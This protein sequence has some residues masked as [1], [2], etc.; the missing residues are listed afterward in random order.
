[1]AEEN[2]TASVPPPCRTM[3]HD[4]TMAD[5][6][7]SNLM[8]EDCHDADVP[9]YD[10]LANVTH[11][12]S[13]VCV[14]PC[15][16]LLLYL[17][18]PASSLVPGHAVR[19][20]IILYIHIYIYIYMMYYQGCVFMYTVICTSIYIYIYIYIIRLLI[21]YIYIVISLYILRMRACVLMPFHS[22]VVDCGVQEYK[23]LALG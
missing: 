8:E 14:F 15:C 7:P 5:P 16:M 17:L 4:G 9:P 1:M 19:D 22:H 11:L 12:P 10:P 20:T 23:E 3:E 6:L 21:L 18:C 13:S 2:H